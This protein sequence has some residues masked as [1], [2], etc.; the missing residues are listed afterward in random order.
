MCAYHGWEG[1]G[2]LAAMLANDNTF[3]ISLSLFLVCIGVRYKSM[4][5]YFIRLRTNY[6]QYMMELRTQYVHG[7]YPK[8][9]STLYTGVYIKTYRLTTYLPLGTRHQQAQTTFFLFS[10]LFITLARSRRRE[11]AIPKIYLARSPL[12]VTK[13]LEPS[14]D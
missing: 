5:N 9:P 3:N 8:K 11:V 12:V 4:I 1:A 6:P 10:F 2:C 14:R 7:I 13:V